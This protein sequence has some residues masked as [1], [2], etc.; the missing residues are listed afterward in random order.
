MSIMTEK[1]TRIKRMEKEFQWYMVR[2]ATNKEEKAIKNLKFELE[3]NN[4]SR[5]VGEIICPKEKQFFLRN[6]KKVEREK[7]MF[8][9]Y[10][11]I[12]MDPIA[13][14]ERTIKTTNFLIEI[15]SNDRGPEPITEKEVQRIFGHVEKTHSEIEFLIDEPIVIV[16]G[17]FN[18]FKASVKEVDKK[19]NRVQVEVM[20]FG[21]PSKV[22]LRYDQIDKIRK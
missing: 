9:G 22:D 7:V 18:G 19:K 16:D 15:M 11:L 17:P 21:Q 5:F 6:K 2:V 1:R 10:I 13:E 14:V 3:V 8:P 12:K 4:L 20:I